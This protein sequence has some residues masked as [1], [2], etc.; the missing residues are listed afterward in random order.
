M[1]HR[2]DL[3]VLAGIVNEH[4]RQLTIQ[5]SDAAKVLSCELAGNRPGESFFGYCIEY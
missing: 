4:G 3:K 1:L 2:V 5:T